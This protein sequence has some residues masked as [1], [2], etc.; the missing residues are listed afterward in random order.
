MMRNVIKI[1]LGMVMVIFLTAAFA[2]RSDKPA[3]ANKTPVPVIPSPMHVMVGIHLISIDQ[4]DLYKGTYAMDVHLVLI[5]DRVCPN[6]N[7]E[8]MNGYITSLFEEKGTPYRKVY[9]LKAQL[10][11]NFQSRDYPFDNYWLRLDIRDQN[12]QIDQLIFEVE[13]S[14]IFIDPKVVLHGWEFRQHIEAHTTRYIHPI[15]KTEYSKY[16]FMFNL[17]RPLLMGFLKVIFPSVIIILFAF[18]SF[19]I[20]ADKSINRISIVSGALLGAVLFH[21]NLTATLPPLGYLTFVDV[22]MLINYVILLFILFENVYVMRVMDQHRAH[23]AAMI[24]KTFIILIPTLWVIAQL[25]NAYFF[26]I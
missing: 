5:C 23:R 8:V 17:K 25:C 22:Y 3:P 7:L 14:L 9:R 12:L 15:L 6:F 19:V 2:L 26:F 4:L 20:N 21:L 16:S 24:D 13:P 10:Q 18:I 1:L 11:D